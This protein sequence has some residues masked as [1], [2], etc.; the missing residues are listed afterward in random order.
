MARGGAD[1]ADDQP[2]KQSEKKTQVSPAQVCGAALASVT[3]AFLGSRLGVAGTV[4][5]AGLTSVV[6]TVGGALY[7]RSIEKT[8]EKASTAAAKAAELRKRRTQLGR[9]VSGEDLGEE[10]PTRKLD[11][12]GMQWPG[13]EA[14]EEQ[15]RDEV[16]EP[17]TELV[18]PPVPRRRWGRWALVGATCAVAFV[19]SMLAVTGF[20]G[21]T[22]RPLSGGDGT[23]LGQVLQPAPRAPEAP[24]RTE[25]PEPTPSAPTPTSEVPPPVQPS[26]PPRTTEQLAPSGP[27]APPTTGPTETGPPTTSSTTTPPASEST[28]PGLPLG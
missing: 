24:D 1:P 12:T 18:S 26:A 23:T 11:V 10:G 6:I 22:G 17:A 19:V 7:Q 4:V 14:V 5:G 8:K 25:A 3:A 16:E 27:S 15:G 21:L 20:E 28:L 2:E 9:P 13:G